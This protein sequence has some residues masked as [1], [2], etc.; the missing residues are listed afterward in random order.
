MPV[1]KSK[2]EWINEAAGS[3]DG[4]ALVG[5]GEVAPP[6]TAKARRLATDFGFLEALS[7]KFERVSK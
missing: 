6:E 1:R 3:F 2:R 7:K 4:A 5:G